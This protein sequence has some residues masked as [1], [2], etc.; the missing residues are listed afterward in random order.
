MNPH[1]IFNSLAS[2]QNLVVRQDSKKASIYLSKF[3][4]LVRFILDSTTEEYILFEK[5]VNTIENY[6]EL[7]KIRFPD[8]FNYV[9]EVDE[10]LD[11]ENILIPPMLT[12]P[13]IENAIEHG[14]SHKKDKGHL[15][16]EFKPTGDFILFE[17]TDDGV[18]R[19]AAA[20]ILKKRNKDH[21]SL[22]TSITSE[23]IDVLNR[24]SK[25]KFKFDIIDLKDDNGEANGTRV[26]FTI[27]IVFR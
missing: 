22:S 2:I 7:Q 18:G 11:V 13:F 12:Q 27:P 9:I 14:F 17:L 21:Q 24:R 8:K 19:E 10:K 5:E 15:H 20:D 1:F 4:E 25:E 6:L 16:I 26:I 23:R 3:S